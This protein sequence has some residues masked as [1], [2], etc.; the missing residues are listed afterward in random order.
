MLDEVPTRLI[1]AYGLI[2]VMGLAVL[3]WIGWRAYHTQ[4][5]RDERA[6]S[7]QAERHRQ[8]DEAAAAAD[9]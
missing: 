3:A 5:R 6:R 8:R 4:Q 2:V 7:R 9:C 1:I